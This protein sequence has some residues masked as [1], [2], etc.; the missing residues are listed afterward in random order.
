MSGPVGWHLNNESWIIRP[1][2]VI[3]KGGD[4]MPVR[5]F[6]SAQYGRIKIGEIETIA[7][8]DFFGAPVFV[9][10]Q[11]EGAQGWLVD[12]H[13]VIIRPVREVQANLRH[14]KKTKY[15]FALPRKQ[16]EKE[17]VFANEETR[18]EFVH[19]DA[20]RRM[21]AGIEECSK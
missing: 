7:E 9:F 5:L 1:V 21:I 8:K 12:F 2:A 14:P 17:P 4:P 6:E 10:S 16:Q 3:E 20:F 19:S 11:I 15:F 13:Q 18:V